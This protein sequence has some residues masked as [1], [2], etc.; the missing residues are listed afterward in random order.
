MKDDSLYDIERKF[1]MENID[2]LR[3]STL[4]KQILNLE[5]ALKDENEKTQLPDVLN[6]ITNLQETLKQTRQVFDK[7]L[8]FFQSEKGHLKKKRINF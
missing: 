5:C 8:I 6:A 1:I 3:R 2:Q 7:K 4:S